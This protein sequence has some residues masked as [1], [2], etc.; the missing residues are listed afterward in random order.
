MLQIDEDLAEDTE[1][2]RILLDREGLQRVKM[3]LEREAATNHPHE[4]FLRLLNADGSRLFGSDTAHWPG[5][6][7]A[8]REQ[9]WIDPEGEPVFATLFDDGDEDGMKAWEEY[10]A[11]T[12]PKKALAEAAALLILKKKMDALWGDEDEGTR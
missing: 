10:V 6:D 12:D 2:F 4:V 5:L 11:E 8:S 3:E 7:A 1:E 9:G